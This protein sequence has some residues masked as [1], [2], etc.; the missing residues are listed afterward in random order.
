MRNL[1]NI[2]VL[3]RKDDENMLKALEEFGD[4]MVSLK[5]K[6]HNYFYFG[7]QFLTFPKKATPSQLL[8]Y[9]NKDKYKYALKSKYRLPGTE[10]AAFAKKAGLHLRNIIES[11]KCYQSLK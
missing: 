6:E 7:Y 4:S 5:S 3:F 1:C 8:E 10:F 9:E 2:V 11:L